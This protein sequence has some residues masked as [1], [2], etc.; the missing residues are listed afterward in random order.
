M[1]QNEKKVIITEKMTEQK[2][3]WKNK[4]KSA[5]KPN[6]TQRSWQPR[7]DW[8]GLFSTDALPSFVSGAVPLHPSG[9]VCTGPEIAQVQILN[10]RP[11]INIKQSQFTAQSSM[12]QG[13]HILYPCCT[14]YSQEYRENI[15]QNTRVFKYQVAMRSAIHHLEQV[16][17]YKF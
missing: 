14:Q 6:S 4:E 10:Q 3:P 16:Q 5:I 9:N 11:I 1:M 15:N 12:K 7:V 2:K 17:K 13:I 8:K